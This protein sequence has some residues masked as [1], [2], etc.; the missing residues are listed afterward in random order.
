MGGNDCSKWT[1]E[2]AV[3]KTPLGGGGGQTK[4]VLETKT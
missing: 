1:P 3:K 4:V 2:K